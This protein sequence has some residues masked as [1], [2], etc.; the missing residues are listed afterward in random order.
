[1]FDMTRTKS[2]KYA[3]KKLQMVLNIN[4]FGFNPESNKF[5]GKLDL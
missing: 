1:M 5:N 2:E 4:S 3:L